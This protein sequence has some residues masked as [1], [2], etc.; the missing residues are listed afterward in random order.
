MTYPQAG[1]I[2]FADMCFFIRHTPPTQHHI[3]HSTVFTQYFDATG[4]F[5]CNCLLKRFKKGNFAHKT[6]LKLLT[7]KTKLLCG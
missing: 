5:F 7:K 4:G 2:R 6:E 3:V 1:I